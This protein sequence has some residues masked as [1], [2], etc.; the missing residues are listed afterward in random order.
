MSIFTLSLG[1]NPCFLYT[2]WRGG[3][4]YLPL[5]FKGKNVYIYPVTGKES[6]SPYPLWRGGNPYFPLPFKGRDGVGMGCF[7]TF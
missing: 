7:P 4:P 3:N 6:L 1:R 5:P 2:F